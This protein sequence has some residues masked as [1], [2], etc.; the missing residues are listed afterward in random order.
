MSNWAD[1]FEERGPRQAQPAERARPETDDLELAP[2]L[3]VYKP[4]VLQR[5]RSR[6]ILMLELRRFEPRSGL[7]TGWQLS[8]PTL[9]S[10]EYTGDMVLSLDFGTR[11]FFLQGRGLDELARHLQQGVVVTVQEYASSLWP[12]APAGPLVTSIQRVGDQPTSAHG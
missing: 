3:S 8:Y 2:D 5:G 4:W 9:M 11:Q 10:A 1:M 7:W 6:P 12:A